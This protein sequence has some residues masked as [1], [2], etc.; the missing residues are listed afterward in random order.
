MPLTDDREY[1]CQ[2]PDEFLDILAGAADTLYKGAIV[3]IGGNGYIKVPGDVATEQ[4]IGVMQK[5]VVAAGANAEHCIIDTGRLRLAKVTQHIVVVHC[6][7][8][9][10]AGNAKYDGM[11]FVIYDGHTGYGVWFAIGATPV[12]AAIAAAGLIAVKVTITAI[13]HDSEIAALLE[14]ALEAAG[15]GASGT[16]NVTT[17][18]HVCTVT[19]VRRSFSHLADGATV[20]AAVGAVITNT[21][22]S[23]AQQADV[24]LLFKAKADDG[25]VYTAE[26]PTA[27]LYLGRCIGLCHGAYAEDYLMIDTRDAANT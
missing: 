11:Y 1:A 26:A 7:D 9:D 24:G 13:L 5:R 10:G 8:D 15:L 20:E 25:V 23:G 17:V 2:D 4:P 12:P 16:F 27:D 21:R 22:L 3:S 14:T 6:N 19:V 18:T